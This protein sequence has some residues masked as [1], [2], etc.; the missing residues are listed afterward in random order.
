M[1]VACSEAP[2]RARPLVSSRRPQAVARARLRRDAPAAALRRLSE[3]AH[4]DRPAR[5]C[6]PALLRSPGRRAGHRDHVF[7]HGSEETRAAIASLERRCTDLE[8]FVVAAVRDDRGLDEGVRRYHHASDGPTR[9]TCGD[10]VRSHRR[11][12]ACDVS[13]S[14]V[15]ACAF[16]IRSRF[17]DTALIATMMLESAIE[18]AAISGRRTNPSGAKIPAAIGSPREL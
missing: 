9:V 14:G 16:G 13:A 2:T 3:D 8:I 6:G 11:Q 17:S 7:R 1:A 15:V 4:R 12:A 5:G 10:D 18:M